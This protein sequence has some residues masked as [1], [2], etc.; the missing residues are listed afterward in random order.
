MDFYRCCRHGASIRQEPSPDGLSGGSIP[1]RSPR[2]GLERTVDV[3]RCRCARS[4]GEGIS[5]YGDGLDTRDTAP[6]VN[7]GKDV[8]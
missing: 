3:G 2:K 1:D 6:L 8:S 4:D 5:A 7:Y